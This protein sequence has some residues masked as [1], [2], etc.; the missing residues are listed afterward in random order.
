M[1]P[2]LPFA[3]LRC[4]I[5]YFSGFFLCAPAGVAKQRRKAR[6]GGKASPFLVGMRRVPCTLESTS[7]TQAGME[8]VVVVRLLHCPARTKSKRSGL[9]GLLRVPFVRV[10]R[11]G[12]VI[13]A[14]TCSSRTP[15]LEGAKGVVEGRVSC[16]SCNG[17][18]RPHD[19]VSDLCSRA[20]IAYL[21]DAR[22]R[23]RGKSGDF[24]WSDLDSN[25]GAGGPSICYSI[26]YSFLHWFRC[27]CMR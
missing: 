15:N 8:L 27:S 11:R 25:P 6:P 21:F 13:V 2:V 10:S 1:W 9:E 7:D 23:G 18:G 4:G 19:Y 26:F 22:T 17:E 3:C 24:R 5:N 14:L 12:V 16:N 20:P